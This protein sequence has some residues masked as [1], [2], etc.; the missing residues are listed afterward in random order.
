MARRVKFRPRFFVLLALLILTVATGVFVFFFSGSRGELKEGDIHMEARVTGVVIRDERSISTEKYQR[1]HYALEEGARAFPEDT[2][3]T[4]YKWGYNDEMAQTL[5]A[6]RA[7]VYSKQM[8]ILEGVE[9]PELTV[10]E[11]SIA[12]TEEAIRACAM[13]GTGTLLEL[14]RELE[15]LLEERSLYLRSTVQPT[16]EL[17]ALYAQEETKLQQ[18]A[19][20]ATEVKATE[21]GLVSFYFDGYEDVLNADKLDTVNASLISAAAKGAAEEAG[22][23]D[24]TK[25]YRLINDGLWYV[26]F[27]CDPASVERTAEGEQYTLLVDGYEDTLYVGTALAPVYA[28]TGVLNMI[29][30][31]IPID[32]MAG[33]RAASATLIK[34]ASGVLAP[35]EALYMQ[36]GAAFISIQEGGAAHEIE[37]DILASDGKDALIRACDGT[38]LYAGMKYRM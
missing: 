18:I 20:Y 14:E 13:D 34:D 33:V 36:D 15:R 28:E 37:V 38:T 19:S 27:V 32:A 16:E 4:V 21:E 11:L 22:S 24:E 10:L 12:Q 23:A 2:V 25:L 1:A 7:E 31:N 5:A 17:N 26:A 35:C 29:E 6:T 9:Y 8:E 3:A 30:F